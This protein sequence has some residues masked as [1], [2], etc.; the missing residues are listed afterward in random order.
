MSDVISKAI[1]RLAYQFEDSAKFQGFLTAFLTE[2]QELENSGLQ[3]LNERYLDTAIGVQLDGIGEIVGVERIMGSIDIIGAFGFDNDPNAQGFG[4][5]LTATIGGNFISYGSNKQLIDDET[6]RKVIRAK[7]IIN[8]TAMTVDDTTRLISFMFGGVPVRYTLTTNLQPVYNIRKIIDQTDI[9]LLDL[10]PILIGI[11][12]V[13]YIS[14]FNE[15][16]FSFSGDPTGLGF[17]SIN[18]P[19]IGGNFSKIIL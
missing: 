3:L 15:D 1:D 13:T 4:T 5:L 10:I 9:F 6:Y 11:E 18:N 7:I 14:S 12:N 19:E 17:G 16:A 2:Y 8:Q